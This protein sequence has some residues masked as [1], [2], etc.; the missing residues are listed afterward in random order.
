MHVVW[1]VKPKKD[2]KFIHKQ[3]NGTFCTSV[4][5]EYTAIGA[6]HGDSCDEGLF[7]PPKAVWGPHLGGPY[8][9]SCSIIIM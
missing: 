2:R 7:P 8:R 5:S 4:Y 6:V 1:V 9:S 3:L